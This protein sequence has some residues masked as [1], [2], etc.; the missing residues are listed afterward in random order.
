MTSLPLLAGRTVDLYFRNTWKQAILEDLVNAAFDHPTKETK[1]SKC[2]DN[3]K[4]KDKIYV[5]TLH[6]E[7]TRLVNIH[8]VPINPFKPNGISHSYQ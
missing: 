5:N 8:C 7:Y 3:I 4:D 6:V 2:D 1:Y